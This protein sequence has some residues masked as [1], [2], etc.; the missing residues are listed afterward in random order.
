MR[1]LVAAGGMTLYTGQIKQLHGEDGVL[2]G[3]TMK[4]ADGDIEVAR[5]F[6]AVFWPDHEAGPGG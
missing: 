6:A 3:V 1:A 2:E 5:Y 4:T